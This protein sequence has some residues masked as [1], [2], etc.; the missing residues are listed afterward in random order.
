MR[1]MENGK[2]K[3]ENGKRKTFS[4]FLKFIK[5]LKLLKKVCAL[6]TF[7]VRK[8]KKPI[9]TAIGKEILFVK[10]FHK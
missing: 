6:T 4:A 3:A 9:A 10:L 7:G 8:T 2:L 5:F 1:R